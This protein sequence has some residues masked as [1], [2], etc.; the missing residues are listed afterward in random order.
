MPVENLKQQLFARLADVG[1]A[2]ANGNRLELLE[3]LAQ[4]ERSVDALAC[5]AGLSVANTSQH[6]QH[7]RRV[8]LVTARKQD[9][10]VFYAIAGEDVLSLMIAL[11]QTAEKNFAEM[12]RL[13]EGYLLSRDSLEPISHDEL[14]ARLKD[15]L[16]TVIDV[17]P[18][19]EFAAGHLPEAINI[20]IDLLD[21][22]LDRLP[23]DGEVV[24]YCR[25]PYCLLSFEAVNRLRDRGISA[26]RMEDGFPEWK[27]AGRVVE[28]TN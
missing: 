16:V 27:F 17:R 26:R 6:L 22:N 25:G 1:K 28:Q 5:L 10:H 12:G 23:A 8:G 3:F 15:G 13:V 20:P 21:Q 9:R 4:K 2:L 14:S 11:R 19:E 24:A 7:L 18:T